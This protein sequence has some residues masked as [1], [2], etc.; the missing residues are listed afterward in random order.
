VIVGAGQ[1][2]HHDV[3]DVQS[4]EPATL[5]VEALSRAAEDNQ[6]LAW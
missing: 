3:E 5:I 6:T 4:S 2:L 1:V